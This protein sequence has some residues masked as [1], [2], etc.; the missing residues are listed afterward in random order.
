MTLS[1]IGCR[2]A[3]CWAPSWLPDLS[4]MHCSQ[5]QGDFYACNEHMGGEKATTPSSFNATPSTAGGSHPKHSSSAGLEPDASARSAAFEEAIPHPGCVTA[6]Q[7]TAQKAFKQME[8][9]TCACEDEVS[10]EQ[11]RVCLWALGF[12]V[13]LETH[14][15]KQH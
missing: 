9:V 14:H 11:N 3:A 15:K 4:L 5:T 7:G 10:E 6:I 1:R 2:G 13:A 8:G 12:P